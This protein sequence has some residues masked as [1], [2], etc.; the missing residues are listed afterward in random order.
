MLVLSAFEVVGRAN[1]K[2]IVAVDVDVM[3]YIK[4]FFSGVRGEYPLS[5]TSAF[6]SARE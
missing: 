1:F 4:P 6:A 3:P 2:D 5:I